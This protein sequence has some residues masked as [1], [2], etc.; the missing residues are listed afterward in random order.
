VSIPTS[1]LSSVRSSTLLVWHVRRLRRWGI[2]CDKPEALASEGIEWGDPEPRI[3]LASLTK[4]SADGGRVLFL[5]QTQ[6]GVVVGAFANRPLSRDVQEGDPA[7][8]SAIF[9][10]EH[11]AGEQRKWQATDPTHAVPV[12]EKFFWFASGLCVGAL[13]YLYA[14]AAPEFRITAVDASFITMKQGGKDGWS[15]TQI[16]RWELWSV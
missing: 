13:G 16:L 4:D 2:P 8:K 7:L 14:R 12:G 9:V 11:P 10:L 1:Q 15:M 3:D 5:G 6:A